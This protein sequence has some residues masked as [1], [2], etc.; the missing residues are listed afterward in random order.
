MTPKNPFTPEEDARL[1]ELVAR[2]GAR[3]W[4][5]IARAMPGRNAG[6]CNARYLHYLDWRICRAP[7]SPAEDIVILAAI[8][9]LGPRWATIALELPG[10]TGHAI[11][12]RWQAIR[13]HAEAAA[14]R[15]VAESVFPRARAPARGRARARDCGDWRGASSSTATESYGDEPG[16]PTPLESPFGSSADLDLHAPCSSYGA[17][18]SPEC[19]IFF[20][21]FDPALGLRDALRATSDSE[22]PIQ[23]RNDGNFM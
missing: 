15:A 12:N 4:A 9:R 23:G 11:K 14:A 16:T 20:D 19:A 22:A 6:Q 7:F 8:S 21:F 3:S 17:A 10:R 2:H 5:R 13:T 1:T 18:P